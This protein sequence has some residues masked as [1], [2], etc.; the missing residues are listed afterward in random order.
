M[1]IKTLELSNY[2]N[3]DNQKIALGPHLNVLVGKNAQGKTNMLEGIF[4]CA[5]GRSPRTT[6]DRD[7]IRWNCSFSKV[8][9][10]ITKRLGH[11]KIE[12][13][14]FNNQNKAIKINGIGIKRMGELMGEFNAIYFS[15]D[16]LKLVKESPDE[17]RRFMDISLSQFSKRYFYNLSKYN[18]VL[19]Q[20]NKLLKTTSN[21]AVIADTISVWNEQLASVGAEI[22]VERV[23]FVDK[24]K[25]YAHDIQQFLTEQKEQLELT[26]VGMVAENVEAIKTMLL[27]AYNSTLDK[28]RTL[29]YTTVGPHRDDIKIVVDG[30]DVRHFGSQGQ[31][32]TAAL[33][34][35]L[36]ELEVFNEN[37]GE[38]PVLLLDDVLSELDKERQ[39]KLLEYASRIQSVIT[40]THFDYDIPH[41]EFI[42]TEGKITQTAVH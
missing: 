10:E 5:I 25:K 33:S 21:P 14:L 19:A 6:K 39:N 15:P 9:L 11:K 23:A 7:L 42:V 31:Q 20:R 29:G 28:D 1:E 16:E 22:I 2:R 41:Y 8:T 3:Y 35:K 30:I 18:E 38:Y 12:L 32:R 37:I 17:R 26:Y 13:Y 24:L 40:C 36:A 34:L 27:A 4:L